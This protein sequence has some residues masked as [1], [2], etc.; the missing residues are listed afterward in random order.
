MKEY[1]FSF[2]ML[3]CYFDDEKWV[4]R[5]INNNADINIKNIDGDT[6]LTIACYF[7][8]INIVKLLIDN[9]A[10]VNVENNDNETPSTISVNNKEIYKIIEEKKKI[11]KTL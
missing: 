8:N 10:D 9:G 5:L 11:G 1:K 2:L 7:N 4:K 6:P 3:A